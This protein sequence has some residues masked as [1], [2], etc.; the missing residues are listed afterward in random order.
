[1]VL[2]SSC[3]PQQHFAS[4]A[5]SGLLPPSLGLVHCSLAPPGCFHTA[6]PSFI[7][8]TKLWSPNLSAQSSS[9]CVR[10]LCAWWLY[11]LFVELS[12]PFPPHTSSCTFLQGFEASLLSQLISSLVRW[13]TEC[14]FLSS[15]KAPSQKC[16]SHPD[17]LFFFF[18]FLISSLSFSPFVLPSYVEG[19]LPFREVL[20]L[21]PAFSRCPMWII[22]VLSSDFHHS[23]LWLIYLFFCHIYSAI[24]SF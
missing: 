10:L 19:L 14:R 8:A 21:L 20:G 1:M 5:Y 16:W 24:V 15:F 23:V 17:S 7:F 2:P 22:A 12:L 18:F 13:P 6:N 4:L 9:K 11:C 3:S